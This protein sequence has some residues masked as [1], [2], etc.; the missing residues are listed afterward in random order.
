MRAE[1]IANGNTEGWLE[2]AMDGNALGLGE[3][4]SGDEGTVDGNKN[5]KILGWNLTVCK[6]C[7]FSP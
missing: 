4:W 3:N 5:G 6:P 2:G 7:P 1:G